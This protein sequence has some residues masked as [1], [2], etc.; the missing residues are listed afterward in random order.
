MILNEFYEYVLLIWVGI[1]TRVIFGDHTRWWCSRD[2]VVPE[3][4]PRTHMQ[5]THS[6]FPAL[7]NLLNL[8]SEIQFEGHFDCFNLVA[9]F[10]DS[11]LI[12]FENREFF[13]MG[14]NSSL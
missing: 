5:I 3:I 6:I 2:Y 8:S 1:I 10:F 13:V 12:K 11:E 4:E 9:F 14:I 7:W